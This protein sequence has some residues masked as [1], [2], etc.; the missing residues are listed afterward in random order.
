MNIFVKI[1]LLVFF[2]VCSFCKNAQGNDKK[3]HPLLKTEQNNPKKRRLNGIEFDNLTKA[4]CSSA[5]VLETYIDK[6]LSPWK[7]WKYVQFVGRCGR[8]SSYVQD[9]QSKDSNVRR[10]AV[11]AFEIIDTEETRRVLLKSGQATLRHRLASQKGSIANPAYNEIKA[12]NSDERSKLFEDFL[13]DLAT[14]RRDL[15]EAEGDTDR[16]TRGWPYESSTEDIVDHSADEILAEMASEMK[17]GVDLMLKAVYMEGYGY[18][19]QLVN[20]AL[21]RIGPSAESAIPYL[22]DHLADP[23]AVNAIVKI[24]DIPFAYELAKKS[25]EWPAYFFVMEEVGTPNAIKTLTES[26]QETLEL[27]LLSD[28]LMY[29]TA[30]NYADSIDSCV[31]NERPRVIP[32]S[33]GVWGSSSVAL[34][35][36]RLVGTI[37]WE[38]AGQK[39]LNALGAGT[40]P[41]GKSDCAGFVAVGAEKI[42]PSQLALFSKTVIFLSTTGSGL[43]IS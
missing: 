40:A 39:D 9:L 36:N 2:A 38:C 4:G 21:A 6:D 16:P 3:A 11:W 32:S 30:P 27:R 33:P 20:K 18:L 13:N 17:A 12:L 15:L 14:R 8:I 25:K 41:H 22:C 31:G 19:G 7:Q 23:A 35:L 29:L 43:P 37:L 42:Y 1:F 26:R 34:L 24:K 28:V 5:P 10:N